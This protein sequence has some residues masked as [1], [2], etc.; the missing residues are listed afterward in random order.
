MSTNMWMS[1]FPKR[2]KDPLDKPLHSPCLTGSTSS[3]SRQKLLPLMGLLL[4]GWIVTG[5]KAMSSP[6]TQPQ[7]GVDVCACQPSVWEFMVDLTLPCPNFTGISGSGFGGHHG[8]STTTTVVQQTCIPP[9]LNQSMVIIDSI[10]I[11]ELDQTQT[12]QTNWFVPGGPFTTGDSFLYQSLLLA[13]LRQPTNFENTTNRTAPIEINSMALPAS[14]LVLFSGRNAEDEDL[15][16]S[17]SV[18]FTSNCT[19]FPLVMGGEETLYTRVVSTDG[20]KR[21]SCQQSPTHEAS[22]AVFELGHN[23]I[24][25][26]FVAFSF[27][28]VHVLCFSAIAR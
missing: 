28:A 1:T 19:I 27:V 21:R 8:N 7:V 25:F 24:F 23:L 5:S 16:A 2:D 4:S 6:P 22:V 9:A 13:Q 18:F 15:E 20:W 11:L 17:W 26:T 10:M 12:A 3:A 14:L